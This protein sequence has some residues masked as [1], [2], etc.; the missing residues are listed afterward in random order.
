MAARLLLIGQWKKRFAVRMLGGSQM[1]YERA[2]LRWWWR[3]ERE[4]GRY[5]AN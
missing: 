1:D 4:L 5:A 3:I 2:T